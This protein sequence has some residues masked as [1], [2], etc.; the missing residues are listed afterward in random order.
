M[1]HYSQSIIYEVALVTHM[2]SWF[3]IGPNHVVALSI[4]GIS[5]YTT[6]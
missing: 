2:K 1:A 6:P 4:T 5:H 3:T